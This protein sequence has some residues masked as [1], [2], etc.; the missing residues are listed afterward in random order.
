MM[1]HKAKDSNRDKGNDRSHKDSLGTGQLLKLLGEQLQL[2]VYF[3]VWYGS[4]C[5]VKKLDAKA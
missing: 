2:F 1:Q 3:V 4:Q 5:G